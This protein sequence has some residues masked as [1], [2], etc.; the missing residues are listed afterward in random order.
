MFNLFKTPARITGTVVA[1]LMASILG[2]SVAVDR[3]QNEG[4]SRDV[5]LRAL[6]KS[7]A[8]LDTAVRQLDEAMDRLRARM[9]AGAPP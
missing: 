9:E 6:E 2:I 4:R 7:T 5:Q 3:L 8:D 1:L